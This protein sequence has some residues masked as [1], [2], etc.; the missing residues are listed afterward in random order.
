MDALSSLPLSPN[1]PLT[2]VVP[3]RSRN[4]RVARQRVDDSTRWGGRYAQAQSRL[5]LIVDDISGENMNDPVT[6]R[7]LAVLA[8]C[9]SIALVAILGSLNSVA[10]WDNNLLAQYEWAY[11]HWPTFER[12]VIPPS[13]FPLVVAQDCATYITP[14]EEDGNL[15]IQ[16]AVQRN[17]INAVNNAAD[18]SGVLGDERLGLQLSQTSSATITNFKKKSKREGEAADALVSSAASTSSANAGGG[19]AKLTSITITASTA[20]SARAAHGLT[21]INHSLTP[22][23]KEMLT[24]LIDALRTKLR[25]ALDKA[26]QLS[27][28]STKEKV[29]TRTSRSN[30]CTARADMLKKIMRDRLNQC[31]GIPINDLFERLRST[32]V[33]KTP[34]DLTHLMK[35]YKDHGVINTVMIRNTELVCLNPPYDFFKTVDSN[36]VPIV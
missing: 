25:Q 32:L 13:S 23:H 14:M 3:P 6:Q 5:Y 31:N 7:C 24:V 10:L 9:R 2:V 16:E 20:A 28:T 34:K 33:V 26:E 30:P 15:D 22:K 21:A 4:N 12:T 11:V 27:T 8:Q 36:G 18:S 19:S 35:E 17:E 1:A 29:N